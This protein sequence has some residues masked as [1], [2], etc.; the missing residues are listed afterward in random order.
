MAPRFCEH[1]FVVFPPNGA[2]RG[3]RL[4]AVAG[5]IFCGQVREVYDDGTVLIT[6]D[7]GEVSKKKSTLD[8]AGNAG[9]KGTGS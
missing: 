4:C 7:S 8:E 3:D 9:G 1:V 2:F 5:C 6:V